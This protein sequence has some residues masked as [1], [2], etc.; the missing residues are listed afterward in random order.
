MSGGGPEFE[1][2]LDGLVEWIARRVVELHIEHHAV[3]HA[4]ALRGT[5]GR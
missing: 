2:V 5:W 4:S 1:A 3:E